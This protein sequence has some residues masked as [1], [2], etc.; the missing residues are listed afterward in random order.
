MLRN[1]L[2]VFCLLLNHLFAFW[3]DCF[4][5]LFLFSGRFCLLSVTG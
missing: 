2:A 3:I 5:P 1:M 4:V